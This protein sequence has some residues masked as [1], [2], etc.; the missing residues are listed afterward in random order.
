MRKE[1]ERAV[2][3]QSSNFLSGYTLYACVCVCVCMLVCGCVAFIRLC[4]QG[5]KAVLSR[6]YVEV[7]PPSE[8]TAGAQGDEPPRVI[9]AE[10]LMEEYLA[11]DCRDL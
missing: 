7:E 1:A 10:G 11:F 3:V 8:C 5:R 4:I 9:E 6:S 2:H